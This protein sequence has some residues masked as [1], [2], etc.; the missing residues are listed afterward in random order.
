MDKAAER[1]YQAD[2]FKNIK[3]N[4]VVS[5]LLNSLGLS[6]QKK[7]D[8]SPLNYFTPDEIA[9]YASSTYSIHKPCSQ[10][11]VYDMLRKNPLTPNTPKFSFQKITYE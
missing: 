2:Q 4:A 10:P 9:A 11:D 5:K 1:K 8:D 7:S 6:Y 3:N